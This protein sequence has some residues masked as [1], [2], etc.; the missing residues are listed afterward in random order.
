MKL[1]CYVTITIFIFSIL[2]EKQKTVTVVQPQMV[3]PDHRH[4]QGAAGGACYT[5]LEASDMAGTIMTT[6]DLQDLIDTEDTQLSNVNILSR[7][8]SASRNVSSSTN[9]TKTMTPGSVQESPCPVKSNLK[10]QDL[11]K[12]YDKY[13][14]HSAKKP[15]PERGGADDE[16]PML[17]VPGG[18]QFVTRRGQVLSPAADMVTHCNKI[19]TRRSVSSPQIVITNHDQYVTD[20]RTV[21]VSDNIETSFIQNQDSHQQHVTNT[22]PYVFTFDTNFDPGRPKL[23]LSD[24]SPLARYNSRRGESVTPCKIPIKNTYIVTTPLSDYSMCYDPTSSEKKSRIP[25]PES[26]KKILPPKPPRTNDT[27]KD[28]NNWENMNNGKNLVNSLKM[29]NK[30]KVS[31]IN[32][33]KI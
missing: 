14:I 27:N 7:N 5:I 10:S 11:V 6:G 13:G 23:M 4:E 31:V 17:V 18:E 1:F 12:L 26:A 30:S 20:R 21:D 22:S 19:Q 9:E 3:R 29:Q 28:F 8:Y 25:R 2:G 33:R 24:K 16:S 15:R 32:E